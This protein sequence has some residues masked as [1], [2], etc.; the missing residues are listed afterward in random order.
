MKKIALIGLAVMALF[1][2]NA[3][4]VKKASQV[5]GKK[6]PHINVF[7]QALRSGDVNAAA[8]ALNYYISEQG[9]S[10]TYADTLAMLYM[11]LGAYP[12]C[13]YW[14]NGRLQQNP[15][16]K[17]LM[18]MKGISLDKMQQPKEAIDVFEKLFKATQNPYHA[19]KLMELQYGIKRL[20]ECLVTANAAEKLTYKPEMIMTYSVGEQVGRT[21]LEAGVLNIHGLTLYDLDKKAEAKSYFEK[22]V[23]LDSNFVLARQNLEAIKL[24]AAGKSAPVN[25]ATNTPGAP[26][27]NKNN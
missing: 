10:N 1:S 26:P 2:V 17:A 16:D 11:Q 23:A 24:E 7:N 5:A 21:Y 3:Q 6:N 4:T 27:A 12:Q 9:A 15:D 14:A 13:Y 20:A 19:Y 8:V 22:A 25:P 18:E